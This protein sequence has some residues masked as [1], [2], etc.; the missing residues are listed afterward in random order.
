MIDTLFY[1]F[2]G[3]A[4]LS[5]AFI[6]VTKNVLYAACSLILSLL[7]VAGL[8]VLAGAEFI[9]VTQIMIYVGGIVVLMIFGVMLTNKL[10]G[11]ALIAGSHNNLLGFIVG[12]GVFSMLAFS[13]YSI[14]KPLL[15]LWLPQQNNVK[16]IGIGLMSD[17]LLPF[18]LA[19][20]I[21]LI[22]L[23]GAGTIAF[24]RKSEGS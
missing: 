22:A 21:L 13:F 9:A 17:Y 15:D 12:I 10:T 6:L 11:K 24:K 19:A 23:I 1:V 14:N 4:V 20:L 8:Y 5:A 7:S 2:G 16:S 3:L 18:E